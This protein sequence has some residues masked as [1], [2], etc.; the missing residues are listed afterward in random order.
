MML[1]DYNKRLKITDVAD[2]IGISRS[3]LTSIFKKELKVSPQE[4]LMN[5]RME[6]AAQL[7]EVTKSPVNIIAAEVGYSDSLSFSKAFKRRYG[8]SPTDYR[9][10]KPELVKKDSKGAYTS[11]Y[12]L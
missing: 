11:K 8:M 1:R 6:K 9:E 4:F 3:Y 7:L 10:H 5:F 12:P 2:V